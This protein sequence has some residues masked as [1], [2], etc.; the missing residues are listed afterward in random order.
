MLKKRTEAGTV[1]AATFAKGIVIGRYA[2]P[3]CATIEYDDDTNRLIIAINA[4]YIA[5]EEIEVRM[6][7]GEDW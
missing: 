5:K 3:G 7:P 4:D 2:N 6:V 1:Y